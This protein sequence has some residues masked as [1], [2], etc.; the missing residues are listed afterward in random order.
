MGI[1]AS[2]VARGTGI[3]TTYKDLS[4]GR[5]RFLPQRIALIAQGQTGV[6]V[7]TTKFQVT[8]GLKQIGDRAGY[9]SPAF[10]AG[11]KFFP[12]NGGGVGSIPVDVF[13]LSPAGGSTA[14]AGEIEVTVTATRSE[15]YFP[16]IGGVRCN[17]VTIAKGETSVSKVL[18]LFRQSIEAKVGCPVTVAHTYGA[19]TDTPGGSNAGDGTL[20]ATVS[21]TPKAGVWT[22]TCTAEASNAGTFTIVDPDGFTVGTVTVAGGAT[23]V[24]GLSITITDGTADYELGD[25]FTITVPSTALVPTVAWTG[26]SGNDVSIE[27]EGP[28][29]AGVTFALTQPTG[30][31]GN[32][33]VD[34]ALAQIGGTWNTLI[35]NCLNIEDTTALDAFQTWGEGRWDEE[36]R[37]PAVVFTGVND[38]TVDAATTISNARSSD[39]VNAQLV[40]P[41]SNNMPFVIA[42][43]QLVKIVNVANDNPPHDYGSQKCFGLNPGTDAEQW[44]YAQRDAAIKRG[45][46]TIEVKDGVVNVSDVVTFYRPT[47]EEPPAYRYV[48]DI[49]K[50]QNVIYNIDLEFTSAAWD[51]KPLIPDGQATVNP[52]AKTPSMAKA[53]LAAIIDGLAAQAIISDPKTAKASITANINSQNPKRL[54]LGVT[55]QIAGNTNIKDISLDF[56]FFF[57]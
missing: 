41:G 39:R 9:R 53:A 6:S 35:L 51:G 47:G 44:T 34:A 18:E 42:A 52:E 27:I 37:K 13:L 25:I 22:A 45:S 8:G 19:V 40:A 11:Q 21:T 28:T 3:T 32:P 17:G 57:G 14:A 31:A 16:I 20:T 43:E 2:A 23:V 56:G 33:T 7:D 29:D 50:L 46:S 36:V 24:A 5:A 54:D 1:S 10:I 4:G 49:V 38:A 12:A 48:C 55:V 26:A 30:G 15:T